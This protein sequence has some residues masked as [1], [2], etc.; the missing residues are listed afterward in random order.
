MPFVVVSK[1]AVSAITED[2]LV[3]VALDSGSSVVGFEIVI[4]G[5]ALFIVYRLLR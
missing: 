1:F 3:V 5:E 4:V 2:G